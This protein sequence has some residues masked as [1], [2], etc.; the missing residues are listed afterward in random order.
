MGAVDQ[1][2][3]FEADEGIILNSASGLFAG[4]G[5]PSGTVPLGSLYIDVASARLWKYISTGWTL[6][7]ADAAS[8]G[9]PY[10]RG[11]NVPSSGFLNSPG[12]VPSNTTGILVGLNSPKITQ[13]NAGSG[14]AATWEVGIYQHDGGGD[15]L[16]L[17]DTVSVV[18]SKSTVFDVDISLT[19]GKHVAIR[20][21]SGSAQNPRVDLIINGSL[22]T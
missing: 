22:A 17:V 2:K 7:L 20:V 9:F 14:N 11:G 3:A 5:D 18:A 10:G 8:P 21:Y 16:T 13:I 19:K 6:Q 12:G 1:T 4:S 15:N